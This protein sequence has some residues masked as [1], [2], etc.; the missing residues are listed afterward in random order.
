MRNV[1][2]RQ[3]T[4]TF[5]LNEHFTCSLIE[6][7]SSPT[8]DGNEFPPTLKLLPIVI[9]KCSS[10]TGDGNCK[11]FDDT[12]CYLIEKCSSPTGDGNTKKWK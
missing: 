7:C 8:G 9:E 10:P 2:P 5:I 3:G 4:E 12:L 11:L 1:V 6:K